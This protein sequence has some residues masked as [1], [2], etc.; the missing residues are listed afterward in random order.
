MTKLGIMLLAE[1]A[2]RGWTYT[3]AAKSIGLDR[4]EVAC[5]EQGKPPVPHIDKLKKFIDAY[6]M[7]T[8]TVLRVYSKMKA[9]FGEKEQPKD[10]RDTKDVAEIVALA[11][12]FVPAYDDAPAATPVVLDP[13]EAVLVMGED[14]LRHIVL[15]KV[16][17]IDSYLLPGI[18][19]QVGIPVKPSLDKER[20][21]KVLLYARCPI[22]CST[23]EHKYMTISSDTPDTV[24]NFCEPC[25]LSFR[26]PYKIMLDTGTK[27]ERERI[28]N[29]KNSI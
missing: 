20:V 10:W 27:I 4:R 9:Q 14:K 11:N 12:A 28:Q 2:K 24:Q 6:S 16:R 23:V 21:F 7:D 25:N 8:K 22:C 1:R 29:E 18:A 26:L 13:S 15:N 5:I 17:A 19:L 3:E